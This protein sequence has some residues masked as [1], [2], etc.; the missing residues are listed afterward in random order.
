MNIPTNIPTKS[1]RENL[2]GLPELICADDYH[3]RIE[4]TYIEKATVTFTAFPQPS[5]YEKRV[6]K[7]IYRCIDGQLS[8]SERIYGKVIPAR[9]ESYEFE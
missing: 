9:T 4:L 3:N 2:Y 6:F 1:P 5:D 8:K 7:V